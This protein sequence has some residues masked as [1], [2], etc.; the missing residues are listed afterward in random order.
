MTRWD[1]FGYVASALVLAAFYMRTMIPLRIVALCSNVAFLIYGIG[2]AL[3]PVWLLS[4]NYG[5]R[6]FQAVMNGFTGTI[7]GEYPKSW[8]KVTLLVVAI[9][10]IILIAL[11]LGSRR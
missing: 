8:L 10:M 1:A 9:I 11:S 4:Y 7:Q 3:T 6:A 2:L 5:A